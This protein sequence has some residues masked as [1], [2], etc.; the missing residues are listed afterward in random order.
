MLEIGQAQGLNAEKLC[1]EWVA[2]AKR[3]GHEELEL[4]SLEQLEQHLIKSHR[5]TPGS[6]RSAPKPRAG[7]GKGGAVNGHG[8]V[9]G[10]TVM[11]QENLDD[12]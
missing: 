1:C 3:R 4:D 2:F 6:R 11:S 8:A 10:L 7:G 9:G 5:K 12:L